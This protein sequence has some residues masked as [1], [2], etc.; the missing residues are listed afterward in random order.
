MIWRRILIGFGLLGALAAAGMV[1][2]VLGV[3]LAAW[4]AFAT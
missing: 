4:Q 3:Y 1:G 2:A